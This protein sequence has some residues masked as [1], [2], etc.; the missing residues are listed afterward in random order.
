M[1]DLLAVIIE[2][3]ED[4]SDIFSEAIR[5]FWAAICFSSWRCWA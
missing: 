2:D 5:A 4:L 1:A 3:E